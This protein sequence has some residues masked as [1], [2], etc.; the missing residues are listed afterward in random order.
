[1]KNI[2][3]IILISVFWCVDYHTMAV[4][5]QSL[6][7]N[8]I[9]MFAH[10]NVFHL[11][12]N[13]FALYV[14]LRKTKF[15]RQVMLLSIGYCIAVMSSF[16][17]PISIPVVGFSSVI[18]ALMGLLL[19]WWKYMALILLQI[20]LTMFFPN[21]AWLLH[22]VCFL[23][24]LSINILVTVYYKRYYAHKKTITRRR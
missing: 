4:T 2:I 6:Y 1:M 8:F 22:L 23:L 15:G 21:I 17:I 5:E 11:L 18:F 10:A 19:R 7:Q 24:G 3:T 14:L 12:C 9:Y 13:I 20:A 16:I